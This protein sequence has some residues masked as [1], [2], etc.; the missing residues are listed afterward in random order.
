MFAIINKF[1]VRGNIIA[2]N[3]SRH[4]VSIIHSTK[5]IPPCT[6]HDKA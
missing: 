2:G 5:L 4:D 3:L 1:N 6:L